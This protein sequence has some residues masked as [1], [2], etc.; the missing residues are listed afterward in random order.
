MINTVSMVTM[1]KRQKKK[2]KMMS[3]NLG[4]IPA[5]YAIHVL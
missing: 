1:K 5:K 3:N 2:K 4:V